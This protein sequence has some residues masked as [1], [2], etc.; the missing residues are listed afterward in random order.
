[1][2]GPAK[3]EEE[4]IMFKGTFTALITPMNANGSVDRAALKALVEEQI[5]SG[6]T[7]LVPMGSTGESPTFSHAEH[8]E[9]IAEV[10]ELAAGRVPVIA[11]TGSNAT[12]EALDLTIKAKEAGADGSLQVAPYYNKPSQEGFYRH[13]S[14][15][16]DNVDLPIIVYNIPGRSAKNIE[17]TTLLRLAQHPNI[18][19]VKEASGDLAQVSDIVQNK[20]EGFTVLSGDDNLTYPILA[21][22]GEGVISV[23]SHL[24]PGPMNEMVQ[25][26]LKDDYIKARNIHFQYMKLFKAMFL[27]TNPIPV[28]TALKLQGKISGHF[29]L[30]LCPM[31]APLEETLQGILQEY[32]L[33]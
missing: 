5:S 25:A 14:T 9:V 7:G 6:I 19:G 12:R 13:F 3:K 16:A 28:K 31:E 15:V 11:G 20:P 17:T 32:Q 18:V 27:D 26:A 4:R 23:A 24:I 30:P 21:L 22:G 33:L 10:V 1:M 29:R 8:I 2:F